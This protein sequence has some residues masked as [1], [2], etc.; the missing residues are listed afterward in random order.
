[1]W[2]KLFNTTHN[3]IT[4]NSYEQLEIGRFFLAYPIAAFS[5]RKTSEAALDELAS[6]PF[7]YLG[8]REHKRLKERILDSKREQLGLVMYDILLGIEKVKGSF[9]DLKEKFKAS[10]IGEVFAEWVITR[11]ED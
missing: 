2:L 6:E 1:L 5:L 7:K 8:D 9:V 3:E 4:L 11:I 10:L